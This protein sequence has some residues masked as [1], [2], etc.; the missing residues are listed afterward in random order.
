MP[1]TVYFSWQLD[2][3]KPENK[4]F[5]WD[6]IQK[7]CDN[8]VESDPEECPRPQEG[9]VGIPGAPNLV[10]VIFNRI[11]RAS[12]FIADL[13]FVGKTTDEKKNIP[14]PNVLIELGYAARCLGW[15]RTILVMNKASG[16]PSQ[17]PFDILQ[18]RWPII[19]E[20]RT[21]TIAREK[22]FEQLVGT[23]TAAIKD[24]STLQLERAKAMAAELDGLCLSL[25]AN[26]LK[27]WPRLDLPIGDG[28]SPVNEM[29]FAIRHLIGVGALQILNFDKMPHYE[30][31]Y[32]GRRMIEYIKKTNP[33]ILS[34]LGPRE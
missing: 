27:N 5:I 11:R 21:T 23:L 6:A 8:L 32:S 16:D 2:T 9:A 26:N 24:C 28:K 10:D 12:I 18:H 4:A 22:R 7:A 31:T 13:T 17:L 3:P 14:N 15:K 19:Y 1:N 34:A 33:K 20:L 29:H 25:I 30:W